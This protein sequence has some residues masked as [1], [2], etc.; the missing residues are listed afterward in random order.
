MKIEIY[1]KY[2]ELDK[3]P[4]FGIEIIDE[5]NQCDAYINWIWFYLG[6]YLGKNRPTI[7]PYK[8]WNWNRKSKSYKNLNN[9]ERQARLIANYIKSKTIKI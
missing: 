6:V 3:E 1:H 9:A 2:S 8:P 4:Q 5:A 7:Y